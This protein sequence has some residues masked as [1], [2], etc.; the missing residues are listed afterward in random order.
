MEWKDFHSMKTDLLTVGAAVLAA[1]FVACGL[2]AETIGPARFDLRRPFEVCAT[3]PADAEA[4][5][6]QAISNDVTRLVRVRAPLGAVSAD[7]LERWHALGVAV[8]A[9]LPAAGARTNAVSAYLQGY[10]GLVAATTDELRFGLSDVTA[11]ARLNEIGR[12]HV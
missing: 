12:A 5:T 2:R 10:D 1:G 7:E 6:S 11:L 8:L 3:P 4:W 9:E